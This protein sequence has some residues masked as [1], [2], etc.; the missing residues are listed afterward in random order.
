ML[1]FP[2]LALRQWIP[3]DEVLTLETSA[4]ERCFHSK[5][6]GT[7]QLPLFF[8]DTLRWFQ[9]HSRLVLRDIQ[10][11]LFYTSSVARQG[12]S[13]LQCL[14]ARERERER[15][16]CKAVLWKKRSSDF[17]FIIVRACKS[18]PDFQRKR[19][20]KSSLC[21]KYYQIYV[22]TIHPQGLSLSLWNFWWSFWL[23][24]NL[25]ICPE[26]DSWCARENRRP[27]SD[28]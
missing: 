17:I 16:P 3:A 9:L 19:K 11:R 2:A 15:L 23:L 22:V 14:G 21:C 25:F 10:T 4:L 8:P 28:L 6:F 1:T 26:R 20:V 12:F 27:V 7:N 13:F 24:E 18:L 5:M